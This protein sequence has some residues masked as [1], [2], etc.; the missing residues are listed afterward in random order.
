[1]TSNPL[2]N[3]PHCPQNMFSGQCQHLK[4]GFQLPP[5]GSKHVFRAMPTPQ[6]PFST[7]PIALKTHLQGSGGTSNPLFN[8]PHCPQN[9]FSGHV[10]TPQTP[11]S[12]HPTAL[13]YTFQG[14][15]GSCKPPLSTHPTAL[16]T[17]FTHQCQH[18]KRGFQVPP[19]R[20]K[21][22]FRAM[23]V[24]QTS[25][26]TTPIALKTHF[27]AMGVPPTPFSTT[28]MALGKMYFCQ[29]ANTSNPLFNCPHCPQIHI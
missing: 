3:C 9:M 18:L 22:V 28:P 21:H 7:A 11:F 23:G 1:M 25:V 6:T 10:P 13:K 4:R 24:P 14:N 27:R 8:C 19:C 12:T 26:S 2:F 16:K 17:H 15:G 5:C 29:H 20:Q